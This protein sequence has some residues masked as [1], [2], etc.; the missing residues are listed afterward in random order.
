MRNFVAFIVLFL[1]AGGVYGKDFQIEG[2]LEFE[3]RN[4]LHTSS[5]GAARKNYASISSL[6]EFGSYDDNDKH[7]LIVKAFARADSGDSRRSH[8]DLREAKYRYVNGDFELTLGVDKVFWGVAEF[9]HLVDII[10]QTDFVESVDGEEK[11][12]Q[13]EPL[14]NLFSILNSVDPQHTQTNSFVPLSKPL[15]EK[16]GSVPCSCVM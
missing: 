13:P 15:C 10:N 8:G 6:I 16:G 2:E 3:L 7:A 9:V 1:S 11:L 5:Y 12:G 4:F 14:S